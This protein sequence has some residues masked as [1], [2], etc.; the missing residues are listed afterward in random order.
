[1]FTHPDRIGQLARE[2]HHQMLAQ[3]SQR[4]LR[5]QHSRPA[6]TTRIIR[7]LAA[8]MRAGVVPAQAP[9]TIWPARPRRLG[10]PQ[11]PGCARRIP[12]MT[13]GDT[14]ADRTRRPQGGVD[15]TAGRDNE[16][17]GRRHVPRWSA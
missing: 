16:A 15:A 17:Q 7:R 3:A 13:V 10:E 4:Q 2:H 11:R 5:H 8:L 14:D 12:A 6:A 9:G 1:M